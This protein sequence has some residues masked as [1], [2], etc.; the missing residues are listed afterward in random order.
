MTDKL[1][2]LRQNRHNLFINPPRD[3]VTVKRPVCDQYAVKGTRL[4]FFNEFLPASRLGLEDV[5]ETDD[6]R[7]CVVGA[8]KQLS[9]AGYR[10]ELRDYFCSG[11]G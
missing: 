3:V 7:P 4:T 1:Q 2:T 9:V 8:V 11:H 10:H 5:G 6:L